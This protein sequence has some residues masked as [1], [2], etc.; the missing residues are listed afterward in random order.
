M[1]SIGSST[2]SNISTGPS[3]NTTGRLDI[4]TSSTLT[5]SDNDLYD[6]VH[7]AKR[8]DI[9]VSASMPGMKRRSAYQLCMPNSYQLPNETDVHM[10]AA[11]ISMAQY[12][13]R[14]NDARTDFE[15]Y[16]AK[17]MLGF[18]SDDNDEIN[19]Q[20]LVFQAH[21]QDY[22][23]IVNF[24]DPGQHRICG[25]MINI[26]VQAGGEFSIQFTNVDNI[27]IRC[28]IQGAENVSET[29]FTHVFT[30]K[31]KQRLAT[32]NPMIIPNKTSSPIKPPEFIYAG[33]AL[34]DA[35]MHPRNGDT[36]VTLN[37]YGAMTSDNGPAD[38]C[39]GDVLK[40]IPYASLKN[41]DVQGNRFSRNI[42]S[43]SFI[44]AIV[45]GIDFDYEHYR[46]NRVTTLEKMKSS[47]KAR[48]SD[49]RQNRPGSDDRKL[50]LIYSP[51]VLMPSRSGFGIHYGESIEDKKNRVGKAVSSCTPY[52]R[53]DWINGHSSEM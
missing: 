24:D 47:R 46:I 11:D 49:P 51:W 12:F 19:R 2:N 6:V 50:N 5:K 18:K 8:G 30:D 3:V 33:V 15:Y 4:N 41:F 35:C 9:M 48:I 28:R 14:L 1:N 34:T 31:L 53:L 27:D 32:N 39:A 20:L 21:M 40:I 16:C 36:A 37:H 17:H 44:Y 42:L 25:K 52:G 43:V 13:T 26:D 7:N 29:L 38:V 23:D 22:G 10:G 45:T